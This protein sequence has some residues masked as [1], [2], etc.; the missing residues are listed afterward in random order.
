M[1]NGNDVMYA[2]FQEHYVLEQQD[3]QLERIKGVNLV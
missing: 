3:D 1:N 2:S